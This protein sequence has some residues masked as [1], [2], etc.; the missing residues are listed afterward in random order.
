[1]KKKWQPG[2]LRA[3]WLCC[4]VA[5]RA[6]AVNVGVVQQPHTMVVATPTAADALAW[7]PLGSIVLWHAPT[8]TSTPAMLRLTHPCAGYVPAAAVLPVRP[9]DRQPIAAL[10]LYTALPTT[11]TAGAAVLASRRLSLAWVDQW[12]V[13]TGAV[14]ALV[15]GDVSE[16][17][18]PVSIADLFAIDKGRF[19]KHHADKAASPGAS[20]EAFRSAREAMLKGDV[21]G[22][23]RFVN[24]IKGAPEGRFEYAADLVFA[25]YRPADPS[26]PTTANATAPARAGAQWPPGPSGQQKPGK[27]MHGRQQGQKFAQYM[28]PEW[29]RPRAAR[30]GPEKTAAQAPGQRQ[31]RRRLTTHGQDGARRRHIDELHG[32][33]QAGQRPRPLLPY[34]PTAFLEGSDAG[35][36]AFA[37]VVAHGVAFLDMQGG[38]AT[39][40]FLVQRRAGGGAAGGNAGAGGGG[41]A[42]GGATYA[43]QHLLERTW[44]ASQEADVLV[45]RFR[46]LNVA[47]AVAPV[48][49]AAS[50][51]AGCLN[52]GVQLSRDRDNKRVRVRVLDKLTELS[53]SGGMVDT[54]V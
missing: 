5:V 37:D 30:H 52:V 17:V 13:G 31:R 28:N 29:P 40:Q 42:G 44:F 15:G 26:A 39:S 46:C 25:F 24:K 32:A 41:G 48:A 3:L 8:N 11:Y 54:L 4:L 35:R 36:S 12:P 20:S 34:P 47:P 21:R 23:E 33:L 10:P 16:E 2:A 9:T 50:R 7:L 45:G 14:G 43:P 18:V 19:V 51:R 1:M 49:G 53:A 6:V 22:A 27:K 38:V